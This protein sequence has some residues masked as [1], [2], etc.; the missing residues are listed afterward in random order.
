MPRH[1]GET[2]RAGAASRR[3]QAG[4][5]GMRSLGGLDAEFRHL[6]VHGGVG[7]H[8]DKWLPGSEEDSLCSQHNVMAVQPIVPGA[9]RFRSAGRHTRPLGPWVDRRGGPARLKP[10]L[11]THCAAVPS[12]AIGGAILRSWL[13][14]STRN[15]G[16]DR[17]FET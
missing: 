10:Q 5:H 17:Y 15:H 12:K 4:C 1:R 8:Q 14:E 16:A 9:G 13:V 11:A 7:H 3:P 6:T 2:S